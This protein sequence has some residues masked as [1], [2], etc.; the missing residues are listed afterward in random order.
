MRLTTRAD[1]AIRTLIYCAVN[2]NALVRR[3][4]IAAACGASENHLGHVV[5]RLGQLGYLETLRGRTGGL[6]L[7]RSPL[8]IRV[9]SVLR[10]FDG[11]AP[12]TECF[13]HDANTCPL[14]A[15]CRL[16]PALRKAVEAFYDELSKLTLLDLVEDS[17]CLHNM[18]ILRPGS[19]KRPP[20]RGTLPGRVAAIAP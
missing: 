10:E 15:G 17:A 9:G 14:I 20:A 19:C 7:G 13:D 18:L 8:T 1:L 5:N 12:L 3:Q 6:R 2:E 4:D 16:R 11:S